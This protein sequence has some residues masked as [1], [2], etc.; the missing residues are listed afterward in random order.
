[1]LLKNNK[2][3]MEKCTPIVFIFFYL[4]YLRHYLEIFP[5]YLIL[6]VLNFLNVIIINKY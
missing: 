2:L 5:Y 6:V 1:M 4:P 3:N